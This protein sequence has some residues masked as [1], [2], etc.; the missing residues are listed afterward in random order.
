MLEFLAV[1]PQ[2]HQP[3]PEGEQFIVTVGLGMTVLRWAIAWAEMAR[4]RFT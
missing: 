3:D 1:E 2:P 4:H